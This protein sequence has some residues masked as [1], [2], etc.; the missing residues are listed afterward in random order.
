MSP[1]PERTPEPRR[2]AAFRCESLAAEARLPRE[3][4]LEDALAALAKTAS[5]LLLV[6]DRPVAAMDLR[7]AHH[8]GADHR[9]AVD[10][11]DEELT[12]DS[13]DEARERLA[14]DPGLPGLI[15]GAAGGEPR[16]VARAIEPIRCAIVMA[17]GL[18][19]R[20][21]PLTDHT[22]K[23]LLEVGGDVLL[24]R[25]LRSLAAHGVERVSISVRHMGDQI[26]RAVDDGTHFGLEA[27]YLEED[28]PL[29]TGAGLAL[30]GSIDEPFFVVNGDL[31]TEANYGA[32]A[33]FHRESGR[34]ATIS[35]HV[36]EMD[37]PYGVV[38]AEGGEVSRI[39]EKPLLR[40]PINA[41]IYAF[42][43]GVLEFVRHGERL[44]MVDF[45]ND[46]LAPR[47]ELGEFPLVE[48]WNDVGTPMSFERAQ[49]EA[50]RL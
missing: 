10:A 11:A 6:G 17:G 21:R 26:K 30:L 5:P 7:R 27:S 44:E 32:L 24:F 3:A 31:L 37:C 13:E 15:L 48:Y 22:P 40:H 47:G 1:S 25:I 42:S 16:L 39:E 35:T 20:L 4:C 41:G 29:G 9:S 14:A 33:R 18:G 46:T 36:H 38:R 8:R 28:D 2:T 19:S 12:A 49:I 45:L 34:L 23:P 43:P 50:S